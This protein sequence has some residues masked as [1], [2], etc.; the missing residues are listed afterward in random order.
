VDIKSA[1][2]NGEFKDGKVIYMCIP[3]GIM[4]M[5][6]KGLALHL[7]K[8]IYRLRQSGQ[9][10]YQ[11]L[12]E[13]LRD[14]LGM[15]R[16]KVD[17]ALFYRIEGE[18][19]MIIVTHVDNLTLVGSTMKEIQKIKA[20]LR[21]HLTISDLGEINWIIGWAI[22]QDCEACTLSISQ[23]SYIIASLQCYGFEDI[24][25]LFTPMDPNVKLSASQSPQTPEEFTAI[26]NK[27]YRE[28]VGTLMYVS[29]G[30]RPDIAY[31]IG[32]LSKF[33]KKPG[34]VH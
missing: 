27:P 6:M 22:T 12:W 8:P 21:L 25:P 19:V 32:I 29:L 31:A 5:E 33:N 28:A 11:K 16:C 17:Q 4:I 34:L 1:Y 10:W 15:K 7:L 2:L 20:G 24:R 14:V 13:I 3:P 9:L 23:T 18:L 30:T 26:K